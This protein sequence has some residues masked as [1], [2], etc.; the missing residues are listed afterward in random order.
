[1]VRYQLTASQSGEVAVLIH[2]GATSSRQWKALAGTLQGTFHVIAPDLYRAD[3]TPSWGGP[4]PYRLEDAARFIS[5]HCLDFDR[6]NLV[7]HS[8]GGA[9]AMEAAAQLGERVGRLVL[10]E[11]AAYPLLRGQPVYDQVTSLYARTVASASRG[12]WMAVAEAFFRAFLGNEA[13]EVMPQER[14]ERS[15]L[16]VRH[17]V[18][19]WEALLRIGRTLEDLKRLLPE[20]TLVVGAPDTW[21][22]LRAVVELLQANFPH[23]RFAELLGGGHMAPLIHPELVNPLMFEFLTA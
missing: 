10:L 13:W 18:H 2:G 6:V 9:V 8:L 22:P 23:W 14:R 19:D 5:Q 17:T 1:M 4:G 16:S 15:A 21:A 11:P 7:G 12:D 20:R 3:G